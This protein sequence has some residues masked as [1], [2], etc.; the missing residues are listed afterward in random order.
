[1]VYHYYACY[2]EVT[3]CVAGEGG[4]FAREIVRR[5]MLTVLYCAGITMWSEAVCL[6]CRDILYST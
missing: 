1:M 2:L 6:R 4:M 5:P 3:V